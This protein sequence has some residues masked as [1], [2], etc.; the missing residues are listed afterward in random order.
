MPDAPHHETHINYTALIP[1]T[2]YI[3]SWSEEREPAAQLIEQ[4]GRG[5]A[6]RDE[7]VT[8]R[9][10]RGVLWYRAS[11]RHGHGQPLFAKVHPLRQRRAMHRL[12]CN[13]CA[14]PADQTDQG[15]LW[16]LRDFREDWPGWPERMG[17]TEPPVCA[18]CVRV[19]SRLCPAL[20]KG[21]VAVRVGHAPIAGVRGALYR[22]GSG[23]VPEPMG[24]IT[25]AYEDPRIRWVRAMN[26]VRELLDCTIVSL[27]ELCQNS[28][29]A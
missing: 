5:I 8:D 15:V 26:L 13:V 22:S 20:R 9:D 17:A 25:V 3:T 28:T 6:Y 1:Y 23:L 10:S 11:S 16:L 29:A 12:L 24:E 19:A 21:A 2:P 14:K 27:D 7:V 18:P 4:P